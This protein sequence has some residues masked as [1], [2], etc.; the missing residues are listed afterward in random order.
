MYRAQ[1]FTL[2]ERPAIHLDARVFSDPDKGDLGRH[3]GR[4]REIIARIVAHEEFGRWMRNAHRTFA[5]VFRN[6]SGGPI[7]L[8]VVFYRSGRHRGVAASE[9]LKGVLSHVEAW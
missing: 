7:I 2:D 5:K 4:H 6:W 8:A 3:A 1:V 9:I